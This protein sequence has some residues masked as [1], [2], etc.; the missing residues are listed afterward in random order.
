MRFAEEVKWN[1]V[2]ETFTSPTI[3]LY[4]IITFCVKY[5]VSLLFLDVQI[6]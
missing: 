2:F 1:Q 5:G 3:V 4:F 6:C